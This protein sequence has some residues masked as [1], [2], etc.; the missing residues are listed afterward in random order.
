[1]KLPASSSHC[2]FHVSSVGIGEGL[3]VSPQL[4][5]KLIGA[6]AGW[7][8]G[9]PGSKCTHPI[10]PAPSRGAASPVPVFND[11]PQKS[12][13]DP[14]IPADQPKRHQVQTPLYPS[15]NPFPSKL[16]ICTAES[17]HLHIKFKPNIPHR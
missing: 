8:G 12:P 2:W 5:S 17:V 13:D 10:S 7:N 14:R 6:A 11:R 15:L 4:G 1:M 9:E 16:R 3:P